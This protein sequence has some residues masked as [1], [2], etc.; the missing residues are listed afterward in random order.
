MYAA[1]TRTRLAGVL[2]A[3]VLTA[4]SLTAAAVPAGAADPVFTVYMSPSGSDTAGGLTQAT[5]MRTIVRV[6]QVLVAHTRQPGAQR[7][8]VL[9][10]GLH[11]PGQQVGDRGQCRVRRDRAHQ[12]VRQTRSTTTTL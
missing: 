1:G 4:A 9:R 2:T 7:Q 3:A 8:Q 12:L 10:H 11:A 6:H 5:A